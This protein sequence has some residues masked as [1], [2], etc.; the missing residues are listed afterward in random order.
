MILELLDT[1]KPDQVAISVTGGA[2]V[3]YAALRQQGDRLARGR[4][5]LG[6]GRGDRIA[7]ALGN[8]LEMVASFLA[9]A[10]AGTAG[11][12][13]PAYKYDEF[14]FYLEDTR[15][16]ALIL[17]PDELPEA[18]RAAGEA[19][20]PV[21]EAGTDSAGPGTFLCSGPTGAPGDTG[22][23]GGGGIALQPPTTGATSPPATGPPTPTDLFAPP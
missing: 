15:A 3:A 13:N 4:N 11:P 18:R 7:I 6:L 14:K 12:L 8:G 2:S 19:G 17:P 23:P 20:I 21:I 9:A 5:R 10:T 22:E 16:R 1:G